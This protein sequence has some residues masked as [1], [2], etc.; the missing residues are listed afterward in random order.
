MRVVEGED[1][2][3]DLGIAHAALD[4]RHPLGEGEVFLQVGLIDCDESLG[5]FEGCLQRV[6]QTPPQR[7]RHD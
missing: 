6:G 3:A 5:Q 7:V 4:A 1:P 2:R